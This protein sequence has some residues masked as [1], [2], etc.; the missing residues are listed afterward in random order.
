MFYLSLNNIYSF[1]G[2]FYFTKIM[3]LYAFVYFVLLLLDFTMRLYVNG[4][5]QGNSADI[6]P[7]RN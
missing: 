1:Y 7:V 3:I 2:T 5:L 4:N 6:F